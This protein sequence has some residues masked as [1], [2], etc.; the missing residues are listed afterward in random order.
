MAT[1]KKIVT[2]LHVERRHTL[3]QQLKRVL[4]GSEEVNMHFSTSV[5]EVAGQREARRA[6][7]TAPHAPAA[8]AS[9]VAM[10]NEKLQVSYCFSTIS[11][12][13]TLR[14]YFPSTRSPFPPA[15]RIPMESATLFAARGFGF[16]APRSA[17]RWMRVRSGRMNCG[18]NCVRS[19]VLNYFFKALAR[20]PGFSS[21]GAALREEFTTV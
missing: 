13:C 7:D 10:F 9:T 2:K 5:D 20:A 11:L 8:G 12:R 14:E 16:S 18:Q 21:V 3:A 4:A 19:L 15:R 6:F 17:S 1:P